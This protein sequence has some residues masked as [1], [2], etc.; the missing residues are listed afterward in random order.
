[1]GAHT[2]DKGRQVLGQRRA[3]TGYTTERDAVYEAIARAASSARHL[4]DAG[5]R[6]GGCHQI[7]ELDAASTGRLRQWSRLLWGQVGH[8]Q[9]GHADRGGALAE[10]LDPHAE[11]GIVVAHQ[12]E[13]SL[14]LAGDAT[15]EIQ[16]GANGGPVIERD[17]TGM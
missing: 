13:R 16:A 17:L 11:D 8:D 9:P 1:M 14:H 12:H 7:D 6:T 15:C 5:I 10:A 3:G 4:L 2:R